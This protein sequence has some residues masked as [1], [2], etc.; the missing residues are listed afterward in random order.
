MPKAT[1]SVSYHVLKSDPE[2][3]E[4]P[5]LLAEDESEADDHEGT[6]KSPLWKALINL[7]GDLEGTGTLALPYVISRSGLIAISGLIVIPFIAF[8][9]LEQS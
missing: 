2:L 9:T 8:W 6:N 4:P 3:N 7:M 5:A 1:C